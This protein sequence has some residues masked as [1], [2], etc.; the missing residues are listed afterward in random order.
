MA[1]PTHPP[2]S[3]RGRSA[4]PGRSMCQPEVRAPVAVSSSEAFDA[5]FTS[6]PPVK[7][8]REGQ[9]EAGPLLRSPFPL[10][11]LLR[12]LRSFHRSRGTGRALVSL[13]SVSPVAVVSPGSTRRSRSRTGSTSSWSAMQIHVVRSR[14][15]FRRTEAAEGAVRRRVGHHRL[16]ADARVIAAVRAQRVITPRDS[17]TAL[18]VTS[19][20]PSMITVD[21]HG[22]E[23]PSH[24]SPD[25]RG[26]SRD[27]TSSSPPG[28][29]TRCR[30][31]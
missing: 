13:P 8:G 7:P 31:S 12:E 18:S 26:R 29:S 11:A 25:G 14:T 1:R 27:P 15:G 9:G 5:S 21:V 4:C 22:G 30:S 2:R 23:P 16:A 17:T 24:V 10:A 28:A 6:P 20:P 19:A 3:A